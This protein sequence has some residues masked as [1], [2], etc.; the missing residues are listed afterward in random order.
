MGMRISAGNPAYC[1]AASRAL[2]APTVSPAED[3]LYPASEL[4]YNDAMRPYRPGSFAT[5]TTITWDLNILP[6]G[7][8]ETFPGSWTASA[9]GGGGSVAQSAVQ[10]NSGTYSALLTSGAAAQAS[11]LYQDLVLRAGDRLKLEVP[12]YGD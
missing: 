6:S 3:P 11:Y 2:L 1:N 8:M 10:K 4:A 12:R 9:G 5:P 7:T